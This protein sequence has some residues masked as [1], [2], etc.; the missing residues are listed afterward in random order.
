M[1]EHDLNYH[2]CEQQFL[3]HH[4]NFSKMEEDLIVLLTNTSLM[5]LQTNLIYFLNKPKLFMV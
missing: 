1:L 2:L 3:R 5:V 4:F